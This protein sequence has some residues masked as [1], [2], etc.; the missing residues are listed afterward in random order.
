MEKKFNLAKKEIT[1][2]PLQEDSKVKFLSNK[3]R[4]RLIEFNQTTVPFQ[5]NKCLH[6]IFEEQVL[7]TPDNIAVIFDNNELTYRELDLR[8][9]KLANF[10]TTRGVGPDKIVG[11]CIERSI[12]LIVGLLGILKAGGAFLPLDPEMPNTR[13]KQII[14]NAGCEICLTQHSLQ[15]KLLMEEVEIIYLDSEWGDIDQQTNQKPTVAVT[16][17]HMISVY[18]TSGS[19]G[20]PKGVINLHK[21]WTNRMNWM[22]S[23]FRLQSSETVLQ[24]TTLTFDDAAVEV[25]WPLMIGG[26]IALIAPGLHR[27]PREIIND[28]IRYNTVHLQ[29]V[30]SMLNMV[31][32]ELT[33]KDRK[34][35][36][37]LRNCISS[38]E[39]LSPATIEHFFEKMPGKLHNTWGAT[40]V[41]I[42]STIHTC[43]EQDIIEHGSVSI[44]KPIDNNEIYILDEF[45]Q[46]VPIGVLGD[47]Y[48]GGIGLAKGYLNDIERTNKA[49]IP[50]PFKTLE[51]MYKTGDRG[52]Y[53]QDGSIKFVGR[54]DNQ[55]KIRGMRVELGEIEAIL[56]KHSLVKETVVILKNEN[57]ELNRLITFIVP[58]KKDSNQV[59]T[60]ENI[61]TYL[62]RELPEYMI[63][64][65]ILFLDDLPLNANG[66]IDHK[67]LSA[68][69]VQTHAHAI[70]HIPPS[71]MAEKLIAEI[72]KELLKLDEVG[73][74]ENFFNLGGHS[75]LA[76]QVASR[77]RR[78]YNIEIPLRSIL[79]KPTISQ[80]AIELE[81]KLIEKI[82]NMTEEEAYNLSIKD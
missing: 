57:D 3:E 37:S 39:A 1:I 76:T 69:N 46:P 51:L 17:D 82:R 18:Y 50:N 71:T 60:V 24:K 30:P 26:R 29:F 65:Y 47:L 55:V 35:L 16:Q 23:K 6:E 34:L 64:S 62:K 21:G 75:L 7:R 78:Q 42:D 27:D 11:I 59:L 12:E 14:N 19:T 33:S 25:F 63:P 20:Q 68:I 10:L 32:D 70:K 54:E 36:S 58:Q 74:D 77:L 2:N 48:I 53:L 9:N 61:R 49:F 43:S 5:N 66:K 79:M 80:L 73:V 28:S 52:Y 44:G 56:L 67:K 45:L 72:W 81:E 8:A 4:Q 13:L 38:G 15:E 40:E 31:L 22:Q 41:S